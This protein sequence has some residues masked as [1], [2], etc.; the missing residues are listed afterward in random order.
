MGRHRQRLKVTVKLVSNGLQGQGYIASLYIILNIM[1]K[2]F[3][4]ILLGN[5][6]FCFFDSKV[7]YQQILVV[8]TDELCPD[9][10]WDIKEPLMV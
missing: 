1:A 7:A 10:L 5:K 2:Y 4:I 3:P 6:F 9:D 8:P